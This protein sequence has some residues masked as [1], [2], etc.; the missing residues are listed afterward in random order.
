MELTQIGR[1]THPCVYLTPDDVELARRNIERYPWARDCA[2]IIVRRADAFIG[3]NPEWI[4]ENCPGQAAPFG[5]GETGCPICVTTYPAWGNADCSFDRPRQVTCPNGH[6][7]PDADHPD[8]GT[9]YL[10]ADGRRH[11]FVAVYNTWVVETYQKWCHWLSH[12]YSITGEERYAETCSVVL[13]ALAEIYPSCTEGPRDWWR[14]DRSGRLSRP[15]YQASR[16]LIKLVDEYDRV[17]NSTSLDAPSFVSGLTRRQNIEENMIKNGAAYCYEQSLEGGVNNGEADYVRGCL[18]VGCLLGI[19]EYID[20]AVDGPYGILALVNNNADR[21]GRYVETSLGYARSCRTLYLTFSEPLINYRSEKYPQGLNLYDNDTFRS[22]YVLPILTM[23]CVGHWPR[24]GDWAPDTD[25]VDP[26]DRSF[27]PLDCLYAEKIHARTSRPEVKKAFGSLLTHLAD[28]DVERFRATSANRE[29]LLFHSDGIPEGDGSLPQELDRRCAASSLM[30]QKGIAILRTPPSGHAQA[31]L[32]RY[33]P[34]LNHGHYDDL[35]INYYG[36]GYELTYDI[37]YGNGVTNTQAGWAKQTASHQLVLVDEVRQQSDTGADDSGGSLHLF[38]GMPGLQVVDADADNVYRSAGVTTY[39]R[40][41]ALVGDGSG[42]YL[43]DLFNVDGG[44]QQDYMAHALSNEIEFDG[45][46]LGEREPGSVGGPEYDWGER[47]L[48]DGYLSGVPRRPNWVAPPG[49]GLGFMMH[50][51]RGDADGPFSATWQLPDGDGSLRMTVLPEP[52]SEIINAWAPG[53]YPPRPKAE[54]VIVRR[55]AEDGQ[56]RSR[57]V[58]IREPYE[59]SASIERAERFE[60]AEGASA[61]AVYLRGGQIHRFIYAGPPT[62]TV[63]VGELTLDGCFAVLRESG[64]RP[65]GTRVIGKSIR[66]G[67]FGVELQYP[68]HAG[69]LTNVDYEQNRVTVDAPLP[70]DG[71]L[72]GQIVTFANAAYTRNTAYTIHRVV[73]DGDRSLIELGTQRTVLGQGTL[74]TDPSSATEMTSATQHDYAR[75]LTRQGVSFFDGKMLRSADGKHETRSVAARY[76]QPFELTVESTAG[77]GAGGTFYYLDI[78]PGDDFV[79]RNW[80]AVDIDQ[81]GRP[82]VVATDDVT[83]TIDGRVHEVPWSLPRVERR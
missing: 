30:G 28:G 66:S 54:H 46:A 15:G 31:C 40:L 77:F 32:L 82:T 49:N 4:R 74:D 83:V 72:E 23:D 8:D 42:S 27:D 75:G 13:D 34:V 80:A 64:G 60:T 48:N 18:A 21:D 12:A 59:G 11:W 55:R 43:L 2:D 36:L 20:W 19:P 24:Y 71:R 63:S 57:F 50:P 10:A 3:R 7:L 14:T 73:Q 5:Y 38:A 78:Y 25:R 6:T 67:G 76:G 45:L 79:I 35:N 53:I 58:T 44:D 17:Y 47:Q 51:R 56:L 29:W 9:G 26:Q 70:T 81:S 37:G 22:F 39:R 61:L 65:A 41:V 33:G 62:R 52:G 1:D 68:E 69:K 16:V